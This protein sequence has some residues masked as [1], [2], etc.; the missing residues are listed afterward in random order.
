M[1]GIIRDLRVMSFF[2]I[3]CHRCFGND[4]SQITISFYL[5]SLIRS[6]KIWDP[7][8]Q[9]IITRRQ[10]PFPWRWGYATCC[11]WHWPCWGG[12]TVTQR[13]QTDHS[14]FF[15]LPRPRFPSVL[16]NGSDLPQKPNDAPLLCSHAREV[17]WPTACPY[18]AALCLEWG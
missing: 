13:N 5:S 9:H 3:S 7:R 16:F 14:H 6:Y 8:H 17:P 2:S 11:G 18:Y 10:K 4:Y 12:V 1:S 15:R